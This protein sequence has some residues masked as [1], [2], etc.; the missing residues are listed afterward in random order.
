M[1]CSIP[2][3]ISHDIRVWRAA[4]CSVPDATGV[5]SG[6]L[7]TARL[8]PGLRAGRS[9]AAEAPAVTRSVRGHFGTPRPTAPSRDLASLT[10]SVAAA[11][12][13]PGSGHTRVRRRDTP[14]ERHRLL[15]APAEVRW[16]VEK[17]HQR[18]TSQ[19]RYWTVVIC[20]VAGI[21]G[22]SS[23]PRA[24]ACC[25]TPCACPK[26]CCFLPVDAAQ[27]KP[28]GVLGSQSIKLI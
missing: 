7:T 14:G 3:C 23:G 1:P 15:R 21:A 9:T 4:F 2:R 18:A 5:P 13:E 27:S 22:R 26:L 10:R 28:A 25:L 24:F 16:W 8:P 12:T 11:A 20:D 6:Q 17:R 19:I